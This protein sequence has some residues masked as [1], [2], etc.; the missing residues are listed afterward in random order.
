MIL[1]GYCPMQVPY[2]VVWTL[3]FVNIITG[4]PGEGTH[5]LCFWAVPSRYKWR[6]QTLEQLGQEIR[7]TACACRQSKSVNQPVVWNEL[8]GNGATR[9][10]ILDIAQY[11]GQALIWH[12]Y[13]SQWEYKMY[14]LSCVNIQYLVIPLLQNETT[15]E[16]LH[17]L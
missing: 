6:L 15:Y 4:I 5:K 1:N 13:I 14:Y 3:S 2:S 12:L 10:K 17:D 7:Q 9:Y 11:C 16:Y 8:W